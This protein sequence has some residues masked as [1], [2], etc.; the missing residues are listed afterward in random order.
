LLCVKL[1]LKL[2]EKKG[3]VFVTSASEEL[4]GYDQKSRANTAGGHHAVIGSVP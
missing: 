3:I 2:A 1:S 4:E